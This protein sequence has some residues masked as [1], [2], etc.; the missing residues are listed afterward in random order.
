[1]NFLNVQLMSC[2]QSVFC[3]EY[4]APD[5]PGFLNFVGTFHDAK[6]KV[7]SF[8]YLLLFVYR[9]EVNILNYFNNAK[10]I[11]CEKCIYL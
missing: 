10:L 1:V 3:S 5:L 8:V 6:S 4:V 2:E 9:I 11:S 7:C